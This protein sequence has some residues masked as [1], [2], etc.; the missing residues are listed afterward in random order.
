[1][2]QLPQPEVVEAVADFQCSIHLGN[3]KN[4]ALGGLLHALLLLCLCSAL[5]QEKRCL[6]RL[7]AV[8]G[9]ADVLSVKLCLT[10]S[11]PLLSNS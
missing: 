9:K 5:E 2:N 4:A 6:L 3:I 7:Q 8:F 10:L 1:M 11:S